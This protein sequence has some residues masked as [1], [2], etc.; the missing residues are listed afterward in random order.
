[1]SPALETFVPMFVETVVAKL[2][3]SPSAAAS[4]LSVSSVAGDES[5][6]AAVAAEI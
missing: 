1:V 4:S 3:S 6:N 2:G 5:T